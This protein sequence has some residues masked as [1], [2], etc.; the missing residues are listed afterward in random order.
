MYTASLNFG[1]SIGIIAS[2]LITIDLSWRYIY[3]VAAALIGSLTIVV[4]FTMPET[5]YNRSQPDTTTESANPTSKDK[6]KN[7]FDD[8]QTPSH[9]EP[10]QP[11][12]LS[13]LRLYRGP[14]TSEPF[15]KLLLR[16]IILF[17]L[18]PVLWATLVMS[19]TIGFL[20]AITSNFATAFS[21]TY[22]FSAWQSGLCF[23]A[24]LLGSG[25]GIIFGGPLSDAI[26]NA[27]TKRNGGLREPEFRLPALTI[28]LVTTPVS[29]ALYG[30]SL[31]HAWHWTIPTIAMGLLNFSIAQATNVSLVYIVDSYRPIAG[32]TVVTQLALKSAFGFLLS[33]Y[34][35]PWIDRVGYQ[36]AF[37]T[38]AGI[39]GFVLMFWVVF[40]VWGKG[41]RH[42][43]LDWPIVRACVRWD[44]DREVGE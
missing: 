11:T 31:Q 35:N 13:S 26:A 4:Y 36:D 22:S 2:G 23:L 5:S 6:L 21:S 44:R 3:W 27:L 18:P 12:Y 42:K 20:V 30:T 29:L 38:M 16:P 39:A 19:V 28:G 15:T 41:I 10:A 25:F 1:V 8:R 17:A 7:A 32:E 37:G 24:G 43:S 34:T 40:Y 14:L 33:F 9:T